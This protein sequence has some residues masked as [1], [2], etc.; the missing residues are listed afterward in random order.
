MAPGPPV[1]PGS[2]SDPPTPVPEAA[3]DPAGALR[4]PFSDARAG[5]RTREWRWR[6]HVGD[7]LAGPPGRW[8]LAASHVRFTFVYGAH[9]DAR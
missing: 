7:L 3:G 9:N 4:D 5:A 1:T 8:R 6:P 2:R